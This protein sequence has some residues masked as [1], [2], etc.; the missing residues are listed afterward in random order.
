MEI[1][2]AYGLSTRGYEW[3]E[4]CRG[5]VRP[6][7]VVML[8]RT[9]GLL[10]APLDNYVFCTM[11]RVLSLSVEEVIVKGKWSCHQSLGF[12]KVW[13]VTYFELILLGF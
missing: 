10:E 7:A 5:F 13:L 9:Q 1:R 6:P 2:F 11:L 8:P 3:L 12:S 4:N